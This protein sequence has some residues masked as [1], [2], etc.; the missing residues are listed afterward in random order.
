MR[1]LVLTL[2]ALSVTAGCA[3]KHDPPV[4]DEAVARSAYRY[5]GPPE[6]TLFTMVSNST[7]SGAHSALMIN[8][9][10]RVIF[11]PA[12][13][14][15]DK[16]IVARDDVV[17]NVTPYV[18]DVYTRFHARKT[19]HVVVQRL[20]VSPEVAEQALQ[21]AQG[22][23]EVPDAMCAQSTSAIL[24]Q[25]P[26][27]N[28]RRTMFPNALSAQFGEVPTV[29]TRSLYEYDDEDRFKALREYDPVKA[30]SAS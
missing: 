3:V 1:K 19:Y 25:L 30:A 7:G 10:Q 18:E 5:D 26:G 17:Y 2:F 12:G 11:D 9:S 16:A 23:G 22:Y 6:L 4:T 29:S 28:V 14:F 15:R 13:S 8:G 24:S 21:L 27:L 20:Q